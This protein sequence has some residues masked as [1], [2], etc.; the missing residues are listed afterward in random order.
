MTKRRIFG[1]EIDPDDIFLDSKNLPKFD[2]WQLEGKLQRPISKNSYIF[3]STV[4]LSVVIIFTGQLF[5]LEIVNGASY[6][7]RSE[8]N[9]LRETLVAADRGIIYDRNRVPLAFNDAGRRYESLGGLAHIVGYVGLANENEALQGF[10]PETLLGKTGV[11][12]I[13]DNI[14]RGVSGMKIEEVDV[15]G[16]VKSESVAKMPISGRELVLSIDTKVQGKLYGFMEE[17]AKDR[18]FT[19]GAGVIMDVSSGEILALAS[20]PSYDANAFS[21]GRDNTKIGS[22]LTDK[23][24]PLLNRAISGR[25]TPGSIVKPI[26]ALSALSLGVVTPETKILSTG[27]IK[28]KNPYGGEDSVFVDWKA[29]GWV[30]VR[31][32]L[33]VSSNVYFY[34]VAGGFEKQKGVGISAIENFMR[35][36]GFDEATGIDLPGEKIGTIPSPRWKA[37]NF[38]GEEWLLGDT[39][40]TAIGQ[41]GFQVTPIEEVRAV[42]AIAS[43]GKLVRPTILKVDRVVAS[44]QIAIDRAHFKVVQEGMRLSV[45][46]GTAKGLNLPAVEV[47]AKTGT[48]QVGV[49]KRKVNSWTMGFFPYEKP[50]YAFAVVMEAGPSDNTVGATYIMMRLMDWMSVNTPEYVYP[51]S[52]AT[53]TQSTP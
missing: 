13:Y 28:V 8:M 18:G 45:L 37:E 14:L 16:V 22:Y 6:R 12:K 38:N 39:Y 4:F 25:Y 27:S 34:E 24:N 26:V 36:F 44:K 43:N 15:K 19:G 50:K 47:A 31:H 11:E 41:Y 3:W 1:R 53:S 30:D 52:Q 49:D 23:R 9:T 42:A 29:H 7:E 10:G 20:Y 48:A 51:K 17:H 46:E 5:R 21:S 40:H 2:K 32:A 35:M 33:S